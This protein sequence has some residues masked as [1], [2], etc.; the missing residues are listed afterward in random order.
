MGSEM[1][2]RDS[3]P[4]EGQRPGVLRLG[5]LRGGHLGQPTGRRGVRRYRRQPLLLGGGGHVRTQRGHLSSLY[6]PGA[7]KGAAAP[8]SLLME[9]H[10][11]RSSPRIKQDAKKG[12]CKRKDFATALFFLVS[13]WHPCRPSTCAAVPERGCFHPLAGCSPGK[14]SASGAGPLRCCSACGQSSCPPCP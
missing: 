11:L 3:R 8:G 14:R 7:E 1:C 6:P 9:P 13:G 2:I 4:S 10:V 5:L 12:R